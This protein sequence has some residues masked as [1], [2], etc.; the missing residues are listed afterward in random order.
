ML[1][2][3][4]FFNL[5]G[6]SLFIFRVACCYYCWCISIADFSQQSLCK[7]AAINMHH[8]YIKLAEQ[9][10]GVFCHKFGLDEKNARTWVSI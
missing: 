2:R 8:V 5:S 10:P 9:S 7:V 3:I 1:A 6:V 4:L